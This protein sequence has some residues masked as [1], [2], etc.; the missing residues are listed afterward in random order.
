MQVF[1]TTDEER[2]VEVNSSHSQKMP[3]LV[4]AFS[5]AVELTGNSHADAIFSGR[6]RQHL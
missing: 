1:L 6:D 5:S 4:L 3:K 2:D